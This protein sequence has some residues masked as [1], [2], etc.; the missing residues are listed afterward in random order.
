MRL[1]M[2]MW[3]GVQCI[4]SCVCLGYS[5]SP[6]SE[7]LN[8]SQA[9]GAR[10]REA[11]NINK[12]LSSLGD[13]FQALS[14]KAAHIPYRNSKLTHLLQPCLGGSGKTLMF[15]NINPEPESGGKPVLPAVC[16]QGECV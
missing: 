11:C 14:T 8:R 1:F 3:G 4:N 13:V 10:A 2:L 7:R 16:G 6:C 12:S 15:V 5:S 9:E